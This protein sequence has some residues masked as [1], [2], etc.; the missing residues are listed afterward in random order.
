MKPSRFISAVLVSLAL[1]L[2]S[3]CS[4]AAPVHFGIRPT[5]DGGYDVIECDADPEI[6]HEQFLSTETAH[7]VLRGGVH[8]PDLRAGEWFW[9]D[10][11]GAPWVPDLPCEG[12]A[13]VQSVSGTGVAMTLLGVVLAFGLPAVL[14]AAIIRFWSRRP[15]QKPGRVF[16]ALVGVYAAWMLIWAALGLRGVALGDGYSI[17]LGM[18]FALPFAAVPIVAVACVLPPFM[19][20]GDWSTYAYPV[21]MVALVL[22]SVLWALVLPFGARWLG[23]RTVES[24]DLETTSAPLP[25]A[26]VPTEDEGSSV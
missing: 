19:P 20:A 2:L 22:G 15:A 12:I 9:V 6:R 11:S 10:S 13:P 3:G 26:I 16:I 7:L 14:I 8:P 24:A 18:V 17:I 5:D 25:E 1:V 4:V 23:F 21:V